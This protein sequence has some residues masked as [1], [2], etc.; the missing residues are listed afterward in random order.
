MV[1]LIEFVENDNDRLRHIRLHERVNDLPDANYSTLKYLMGH[2]YKV[3][4]HQK[5]NAMT[6]HNIAVIFGPTLFGPPILVQSPMPNGNGPGTAGIGDMGLQ[7]KV[8]LSVL[9]MA[10]VLMCDARPLRLS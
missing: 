10:S 5:E 2:L 8:R 9:N 1:G 6:T 7:I 3:V 4:E